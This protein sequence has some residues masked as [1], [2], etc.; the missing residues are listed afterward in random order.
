[1][2]LGVRRHFAF[3]AAQKQFPPLRAHCL[4][5]RPAFEGDAEAPSGAR[6]EWYQNPV[7]DAFHHKMSGE[8]EMQVLI[9]FQ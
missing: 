5:S 8:V 9:F 4:T 6:G 1:M 2:R 7:Q 3:A